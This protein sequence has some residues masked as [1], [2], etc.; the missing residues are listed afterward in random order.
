MSTSKLFILRNVCCCLHFCLKLCRNYSRGLE[1]RIFSAKRVS[2][3]KDLFL[4]GLQARCVPKGVGVFLCICMKKAGDS[5]QGECGACF[6]SLELFVHRT[7]LI[8]SALRWLR[9]F[10]KEFRLLN[11]WIKGTREKFLLQTVAKCQEQGVVKK[12][13]IVLSINYVFSC[14]DFTLA[15]AIFDTAGSL[16]PAQLTLGWI[17]RSIIRGLTKPSHFLLPLLLRSVDPAAFVGCPVR[18]DEPRR[19]VSGR[20]A[21]V[22]GRS[23]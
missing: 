23:R 14:T 17:H 12:F 22:D 18:P 8:S 2:E 16:F 5:G 6:T 10:R 21:L 13:C 3:Q 7:E 19:Q 11:L 1:Q 15:T 9:E 20:K 4:S